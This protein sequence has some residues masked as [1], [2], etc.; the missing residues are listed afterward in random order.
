MEDECVRRLVH[1]ISPA[2]DVGQSEVC[3]SNRRLVVRR[4][5][6]SMMAHIGEPLTMVDLC[7]Q[8]GVSER[9]LHYAFQ[10]LLG[11]SPMAYLM[12]KR[13][14][15]V[16]RELKAADPDFETV[17]EI[18]ARWGFWHTGNFAAHYRRLFDELPRRRFGMGPK[19]VPVFGNLPS[20]NSTPSNTAAP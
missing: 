7:A 11:M 1:A 8:V 10:A 3:A 4:A 20:E 9:T 18:A 15:G 12:A 2:G 5:E 13:L 17:L 14:N 19:Q 16:R 6:D